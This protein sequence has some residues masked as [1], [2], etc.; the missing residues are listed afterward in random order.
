MN[1]VVKNS[2]KKLDKLGESV[3]YREQRDKALLGK[4]PSFEE[5]MKSERAALAK[6]NGSNGHTGN[7]QQAVEQKETKPTKGGKPKLSGESRWAFAAA[8]GE[9]IDLPLELIHRHP[10]NRQPA[11]PAVAQLAESIE[12]HK[13]Q[14]PILVRVP[15]IGTRLDRGERLPGGGE[16]LQGDH[17]QIVFGERR[18]LAHKLLKLP[19]IRC[20]VRTD[21]SDIDALKLMAEENAKRSDLNPVERARLIET[22]IA[23]IADGG[24][25]M[26]VKDAAVHVGFNDAASASNALRLL[27]LPAKWLDRV[28]G[29]ELAETFARLLVPICHAPKLMDLADSIWQAHAKGQDWKP[30]KGLHYGNCGSGFDTRGEVE[31]LVK[32][33]LREATRPME[34]THQYNSYELGIPYDRYPKLFEA[35]DATLA[36]LD[37]Q[38]FTVSKETERLA[39]NWKLYDELQLPAIKKHL[40]QKKTK[41]AAKKG[42]DK[43][44]KKALTPAEQKKRDADADEQ[45][46]KHFAA[47]RHDWL[48]WLVAERLDSDGPLR[49]RVL[50]ALALHEFPTGPEADEAV[51]AAVGKYL[52][53]KTASWGY[54]AIAAAERS[55]QA[56]CA[57]QVAICYASLTQ[58]DQNWRYPSIDHGTIDELAVFIGLDLAAAWE[59]LQKPSVPKEPLIDRLGRL[60]ELFQ[61]HNSRQLDALGKELGVHVADA[62]SKDAKV[63]ILMSRD[64]LLKLPKCIAPLPA[65][66]AARKGAKPRRGK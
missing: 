50:M 41:T 61:L 52:K 25:G 22:L 21:L 48:R 55:T 26:M 58:T 20:Y 49:E 60:E 47:W 17:V 28:A 30:A 40:E 53:T 16:Y 1:T 64:R 39:T 18:Y 2:G 35:D 66:K 45:L 38:E 29:G 13:L 7:G 3:K 8:R 62:R 51:E 9:A 42:R 43:P 10:K 23:P 14:Q 33:L 4:R 54:S 6:R 59:H 36:K 15:P 31:A 12:K 5:V 46:G 65:A 11:A 37:V 32:Y 57:A 56:L 27:K 24:G 63:N 34:G 44:A 19:S